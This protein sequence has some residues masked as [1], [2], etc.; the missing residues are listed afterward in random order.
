MPTWRGSSA[1][2]PA[3][4]SSRSTCSAGRRPSRRD[5]LFQVTAVGDGY[6]GLEHRSSTSLLCKPRRVCRCRAPR[7]HRDDYR[8][9]P[10]SRQP[11]VLPRVEREADQARGVRAV[12]PVARRLHASAVGV[13]GHHVLLRRPRAGAQRRDLHVQAIWS[14]SAAHITNVLRGPG[15]NVQ[16]IADSSFDAWIKFYRADENSPNAVV[17]YY[18]KGALVALRAR[19][20]AAPRRAHDARRPDA[21]ALAALRRARHRRARGRHPY[22]R[23]RAGRPRLE[24]VLRTLRGWHRGSAAGGAAQQSRY[25]ARI[26]R[27]HRRQRSRRQARN[28]TRTSR[29][30]L[31]AEVGADLKLQH[32]FTA[33]PAE[34]AGLAAGDTLVA[35]RRRARVGRRGSKRC[36]SGCRKAR[37]VPMHAFPP[38]RADAIDRRCWPR[39]RS[40]PAG[41]PSTTRRRTRR[42]HGAPRG[43]ATSIARA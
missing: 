4:A 16:S 8:Q 28:G 34:R 19:P 40:T 1:I 42:S 23:V 14:C 7:T 32:V 10:R 38:R 13:R 2:S 41:S 29:A 37:S 3:S 39:R 11:R 6:G 36:S 27:G 20:H 26:A 43:S 12:R 25:R 17:S 9:L 5:Y 18:A 15:R 24:R 30:W 31:G 35:I 21:R 33:G 22:A